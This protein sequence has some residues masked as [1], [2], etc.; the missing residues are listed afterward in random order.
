MNPAEPELRHWQHELDCARVARDP[1]LAVSVRIRD[2]RLETPEQRH[3]ATIEERDWWLRNDREALE[4]AN[5]APSKGRRP[6]ALDGFTAIFGQQPAPL[7]T[8]AELHLLSTILLQ[9]LTLVE[10]PPVSLNEQT[11]ARVKAIQRKAIESAFMGV[12]R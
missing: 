2:P 5:R 9:W 10:G 4:R 7:F 6:G 12:S 8:P 3:R 1:D 11:I